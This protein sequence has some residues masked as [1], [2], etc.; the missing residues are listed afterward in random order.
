MSYLQRI[1]IYSLGLAFCTYFIVDI[2]IIYFNRDIQTD[3][4][5]DHDYFPDPGISIC[6]PRK[7]KINSMREK[8]T[9][10]LNETRFTKGG[11]SCFRIDP[12][13]ILRNKY[14]IHTFYLNSTRQYRFHY[15][16]H[17]NNS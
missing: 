12:R 11:E 2:S 6:L 7:D 4:G 13:S 1:L 10:G 8:F 17:K 15:Y 16:N 5:F 14:G 3:Y 9:I